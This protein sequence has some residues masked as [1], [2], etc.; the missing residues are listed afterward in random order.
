[1]RLVP[2][3]PESV[4]C[5]LFSLTH[6]LPGVCTPAHNDVISLGW[7][8]LMGRLSK[9]IRASQFARPVDSALLC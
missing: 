6:Q 4:F 5:I 3:P 8:A 1:M 9:G 2:S 7:L